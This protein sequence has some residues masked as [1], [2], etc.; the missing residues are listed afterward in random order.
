MISFLSLRTTEANE[1]SLTKTILLEHP[2]IWNC[3][4]D[5]ILNEGLTSISHG[6]CQ[7]TSLTSL[8]LSYWKKW[9]AFT[10]LFPLSKFNINFFATKAF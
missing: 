4:G 1:G 6:L 5:E 8:N 3:A 9:T 7:N 10:R 2:N